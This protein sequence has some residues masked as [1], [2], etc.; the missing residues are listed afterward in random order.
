MRAVEPNLTIPS[1]YCAL[2]PWGERDG[3]RG[4][5]KEERGAGCFGSVLA[6]RAHSEG[7]LTGRGRVLA[8]PGLGGCDNARNRAKAARWKRDE[9]NK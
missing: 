5:E 2:P 9:E 6:H 4:K 7:A 3:V 1:D 8:R